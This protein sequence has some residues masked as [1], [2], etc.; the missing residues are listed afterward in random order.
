MKYLIGIGIMAMGTA[1]GILGNDV[2][3][4]M[5]WGGGIW[6]MVRE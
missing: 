2:M 4:M 3:G 5:L 1:A 6:S